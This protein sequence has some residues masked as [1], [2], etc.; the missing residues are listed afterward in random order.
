VNYTFIYL[1]INKKREK[2]MILN[3]LYQR[4][5]AAYQDLKQDN[6]QTQLGDL[7]KTKLTLRQLRKLRQLQDVRAVEHREK[8]GLIRQQYGTPP[9]DAGGGL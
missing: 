5:P 2:K 1:V 6:S 7:R 4:S 3:E 9:A 8:L